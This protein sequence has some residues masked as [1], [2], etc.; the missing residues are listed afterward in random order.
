MGCGPGSF[1]VRLSTTVAGCFTV[2]R[3]TSSKKINHHRIDYKG[4]EGFSTR[5]V[6]NRSL[7]I[8]SANKS[9]RS[10]IQMLKKDMNLNSACPGSKFQVLFK[11]Q[12]VQSSQGGYDADL[13]E[14]NVE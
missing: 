8:K 4:I 2:S 9:L 14:E 1:L 12:V 6:V 3:V 10:F 11:V 5:S 7:T 13:Y